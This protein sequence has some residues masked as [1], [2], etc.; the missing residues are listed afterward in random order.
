V[1]QQLESLLSEVILPLKWSWGAASPKDKLLRLMLGA[2]PFI[3]LPIPFSFLATFLPSLF[4]LSL[5]EPLV[6]KL[7]L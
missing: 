6:S 5:W 3:T 1:L 2:S 7:H 4:C